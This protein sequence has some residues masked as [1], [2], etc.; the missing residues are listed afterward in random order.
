[1]S[2]DRMY[3]QRSEASAIG[4]PRISV[5]FDCECSEEDTQPG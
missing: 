1:M 3:L 5:S 4:N 2:S